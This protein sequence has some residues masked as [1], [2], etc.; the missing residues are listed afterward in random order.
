MQDLIHIGGVSK[1]NQ[2]PIPD[3]LAE[4]HRSTLSTEKTMRGWTLIRLHKPA[5]TPCNH[6]TLCTDVN[7]KATGQR[8]GSGGG[9]GIEFIIQKPDCDGGSGEKAVVESQK[10]ENWPP[11]ASEYGYKCRRSVSEKPS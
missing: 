8:E 7:P 11:R 5:A 10:W 6:K 4:K 1:S 3:E 2:R 9:G